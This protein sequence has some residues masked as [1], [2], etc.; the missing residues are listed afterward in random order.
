ME[1]Q[2]TVARGRN[3]D[4]VVLAVDGLALPRQP[5][6]VAELVQAAP[7]GQRRRHVLVVARHERH[8]PLE[9]RLQL[10]SNLPYVASTR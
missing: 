5:R 9:L 7:R 2:K 10:K 1:V 8:R 3:V 4:A 6:D